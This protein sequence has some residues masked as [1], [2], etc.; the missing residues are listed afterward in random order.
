MS[1][2]GDI[3]LCDNQLFIAI[4]IK[5][6]SS[7]LFM[8]S[9]ILLF[10]IA[11]TACLFTF[12]SRQQFLLSQATAQIPKTS[13]TNDPKIIYLVNAYKQSAQKKFESKNFRAAIADL[14]RIIQIDPKNHLAYYNRGFVKVAARDPQLGN[15]QTSLS[16]YNLAIKIAPKTG[17]Y[18]AARAALKA[19]EFKDYGG[20]V[21]D[22]NLAIELNPNKSSADVP[23]YYGIRG[24]IKY[25]WLNDKTGGITDTKQAVK[26]FKQQRNLYWYEFALKKLKIME[27]DG[28]FD[29]QKGWNQANNS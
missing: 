2:K 14:D 7:S 15:P 23:H 19:N 21:S 9:R 16:D 10:L 22:Y 3:S 4:H 24:Y 29:N 8:K 6:T 17:V 1:L 13:T 28:K 26:I 25:Q 20:A 11:F 5:E 12:G 18:Y 27:S